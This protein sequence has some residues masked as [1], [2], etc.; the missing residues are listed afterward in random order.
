MG[1]IKT[2]LFVCTGNS[3][4]SVMA[5]GL[6][7]KYLKDEGRDD[8]EVASAGARA[9]DGIEPTKE[10]IEVMR[11]EGADVSNHRSRG[12]TDELI[13]KADLILV[14]SA[15]HMDDIVNMVPEAAP[16]VHMLKEY[17]L[18][19]QPCA[20]EDTGI[21]D[22]IGRPVSFYREV[23]AAIKKELKR[24]LKERLI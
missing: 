17:G 4:R 18:K 1:K 3:C 22:P 10:T 20:C 9:I 14:M 24:I 7:K 13:K 19:E 16:K 11:S 12:L 21:E 15:H 23:L 5:E 8:I 6:L 2:I